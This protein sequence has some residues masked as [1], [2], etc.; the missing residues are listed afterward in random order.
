MLVASLVF[1]GLW[2]SHEQSVVQTTLTARNLSTVLKS[3]L[4]FSGRSIDL[5]LQGIGEALES[6]LKLGPLDDSEVEALLEVKSKFHLEVTTFRVS[7]PNGI[8]WWGNG[9][10]RS[11]PVSAAGRD[12]FAYHLAN[13]GVSLI[14]TP[15]LVGSVTKQSVIAFVRSFRYPDGR[16]AGVITASVPVTYFNQLL[17]K[18]ELGPH[19][20][21]AIRHQDQTLITLF[22][23]PKGEDLL[24]GTKKISPELKEL[25][26]K[27]VEYA[28][29]RTSNSPDGIDRLYSISRVPDL[30]LIVVVGFSPADYLEGWKR[31]IRY[32]GAMLLVL[33]LV[34]FFGTR[35]ILKQWQARIQNEIKLESVLLEQSAMLDN[36]LVGIVRVKDRKIIWANRAFELIFGYGPNELTERQTRD[37]Y[38]SEAAFLE[39]GAAAYPVLANGKTFRYQMEMMRKDGIRVW[40]NISGGKLAGTDSDTLWAFIDISE[41]HSLEQAITQSQ[42][43]ME[44]ALASGDLAIWDLDLN[45]NCFVDSRK[46]FA[47]LGYGPDELDQSVE[48]YRSLIHRV[49]APNMAEAFKVHLKGESSSFEMEYR[50]RRKDDQWAWIQSRAR[51]VE[52][53]SDGRA[54]RVTGTNLDISQRKHDEALLKERETRLATLISS[55]QDLIVVMDTGGTIVEFIQPNFARRRAYA[56]P[57]TMIGKPFSEVL[58]SDVA[59]LYSEALDN[60]LIGGGVQTFEYALTIDGTIFISQAKMSPMGKEKFPTGFL[61]I[62]RDVTEERALQRELSNSEIS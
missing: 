9:V 20:I 40:V 12:Y 62:I 43:R 56:P 7:K 38:P 10:D 19:G 47:M 49:D 46:I 18:L 52:R 58:P 55:M 33:V 23:L 29:Y 48:T 13:P 35:A 27:N 50:I 30:P 21:A 57:E 15:P 22:P 5:A 60:C 11:N 42:Q 44:L 16:F 39:F 17:S 45:T 28:E 37:L 14:V 25:M 4:E 2:I 61:T 51:V 6:K 53:E 32:S 54:I 26:E 36:E 8:V 34:S 3:N 41:Q 24:S 59:Q 31:E 1:R